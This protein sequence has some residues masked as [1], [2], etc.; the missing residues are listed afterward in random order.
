[1]S[2][3]V[4]LV[5]SCMFIVAFWYFVWKFSVKIFRQK[6]GVIPMI[7]QEKI[8]NVKLRQE[9]DAAMLKSQEEYIA[10]C[11]SLVSGYYKTD[12]F[13]PEKSFIYSTKRKFHPSYVVNGLYFSSVQDKLFYFHIE[14]SGKIPKNDIKDEI[15]LSK[16]ISFEKESNIS[17]T[18]MSD[19]GDIFY[20]VNYLGVSILMDDGT[21]TKVLLAK[22]NN[23]M[24]TRSDRHSGKD[25][26]NSKIMQDYNRLSD[27]LTARLALYNKRSL[28]KK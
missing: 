24:Y 18:L 28:L 27:A 23:F 4:G 12:R 26:T 7:T 5:A 17:R 21:R 19:T 10:F 20:D 2:E 13:S 1:M 8:S 25:F 3:F 9:Q 14:F 15:Y 22:K 6:P 11:N 16:I